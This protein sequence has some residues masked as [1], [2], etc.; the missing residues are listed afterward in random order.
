MQQP[1][2]VHLLY[3]L[4]GATGSLGHWAY[5]IAAFAAIL[6]ICRRV[7]AMS[8]AKLLPRIGLVWPTGMARPF[9]LYARQNAIKRAQF[10]F[11]APSGALQNFD[12][13]SQCLILPRSSSYNQDLFYV[14]LKV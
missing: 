11:E 6:S 10:V 2:E 7:H 3:E 8:I 9:A 14:S 13:T 12:P 5:L 4:A 1:P